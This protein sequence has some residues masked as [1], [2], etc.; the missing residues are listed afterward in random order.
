MLLFSSATYCHFP[1]TVRQGTE[2]PVPST[3][4]AELCVGLQG[5]A[6]YLSPSLT[7]MVPLRKLFF[8]GE[9]HDCWGP[10]WRECD[11]SPGAVYQQNYIDTSGFFHV[12]A[13]TNAKM[14]CLSS[15]WTRILIKKKKKKDFVLYYRP[16][17]LSHKFHQ[18][19]VVPS[20][21]LS[22]TQ[23]SRCCRA[24]KIKVATDTVQWLSHYNDS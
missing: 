4:A 15:S 16:L 10:A 2:I 9:I 7:N 1:K 3:A 13:R 5:T 6:S 19:G 21:L 24:K 18:A 23:Q 12:L 8:L 22:K 17:F 14:L 20:Y 11:T